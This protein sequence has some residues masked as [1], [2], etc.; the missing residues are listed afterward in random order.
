LVI[1]ATG[2][3]GTPS[4]H[5]LLSLRFML[6]SAISA[7]TSAK[8]ASNENA[9]KEIDLLTKEA[10]ASSGA[11]SSG[12][13]L[14]SSNTSLADV[15]EA[16]RKNSSQTNYSK[17]LNENNSTERTRH[18]IQ[19]D[20]D[21]LDVLLIVRT[22]SRQMANS[23]ELVKLL[24]LLSSG[25]DLMPESSHLLSQKNISDYP[26]FNLH[27][28]DDSALPKTQVSI[29]FVCRGSMI[30]FRYVYQSHTMPLFCRLKHLP[31]SPMRQ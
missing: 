21:K 29:C 15:D 31:C 19:R 27:F 25:S 1:P 13:H 14:S 28:F 7:R 16:L 26:P 20:K 8:A 5:Q 30:V 23:K 2:S 10:T 6:L 22:K 18:Y 12:D 3:C 24:Q 17:S 11:G 9:G 4:R